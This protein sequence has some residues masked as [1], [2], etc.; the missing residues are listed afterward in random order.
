MAEQKCR[1]V[2]KALFYLTLLIE[3]GIVLVDKSAY[4]NP[5]EG[6]LFR[7][8]RSYGDVSAR[9]YGDGIFGRQLQES[10]N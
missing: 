4:I 3:L 6:Q 5:I 7:R 2:G 8:A 10:W 9:H 1:Q